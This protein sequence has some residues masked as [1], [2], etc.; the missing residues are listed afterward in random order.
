MRTGQPEPGQEDTSRVADPD[1]VLPKDWRTSPDRV[2]TVLGDAEGLHVLAADSTTA[3]Q[4]G[5]VATL[6]EDGFDSDAWIGNICVTGSGRRAVVA[7]APR[8]FTN[9]P[10][11][12]DRG[13]FTAVVDLEKRTVTK[14]AQQSSL[15]YF[16]PGCGTGET[17]VLTQAADEEVGKTRFLSVDTGTGTVTGDFTVAG[18]ATSAVP[19]QEGVVT[20][21][22]DR[23]TRVGRDGHAELI[24]KTSGPAFHIHPDAEGGVGFL[25]R[26]GD[27]VSVK[28][29]VAGRTTELA[30]GGLGKL[31]LTAGTQGRLFLTG[32][33]QTLATLPAVVKPLKA[34]VG[35][36]TSSHGRLVLDTAVSS[37][38]RTHVAQPLAPVDPAEGAPFRIDAHVPGTGKQ[39]AFTVPQSPAATVGVRSPAL[40]NGP[41]TSASTSPSAAVRA[42]AT[43]S[44]NTTYDPERTC[45]VPRN[46]PAQQALQPTPNQ[47][48]W[49]ADMAIRGNLTSNY[50]AQG[51]WRAEDGLGTAVAPSAMFPQSALIG[52][53]AGSRIPAQ[54]LLGV[55]AQESNLWQASYHALPGQTGN[56]VVGNFY[57]TNIYPG[58]TGYDPEKV[59]TVNWA[60]ADCG[61]GIGQQTDGMSVPGRVQE[62]GKPPAMSADKQRAVALDYAANIAVA[63]Q[64]LSDKWSELH[65]PG[66][67]IK[68]NNDDPKYIENWFAAV[69]NYNLGF[70]KPDAQGK[71]GLGWL[72]NPANP[73]YPADRNAFLDNNHYADAAT[74]QKWPY[75][76]KVMGWAAFPI[77]TGRSY[78]DAGQQ[79]SGNTHGYQAAWWADVAS[80]TGAIKPPLDTFCNAT[81][82]CS[83]GSPPQCGT[84]Y[85]Y[86]QYWYHSDVR[87]KDCPASC[88]N[89]TLTYKTL[90]AELGRGSSGQPNC[91]LSGIP[92]GA[93]VI[94]DVAP[95]VPTMRAGCGKP[96]TSAGSLTWDFAPSSGSTTTYE[97][98]ED[99]H[100][101]GGGLGSHFWFAHTRGGD[102]RITQMR[103]TGTWSLNRDLNQWARVLVHLP[104]TGAETHQA[105]YTIGLGDGTT[106]TRYL[107]QNF[108]SNRWVSLGT[109][110]FKGTPRV[111]LGNETADGTADQDV[112][113]DA[114]AFQPL[115]AKPQHMV[116]VLGDSYTSGEGAGS[117]SPESDANHGK[118][119]WSACRR[120]DNAWA[121]KL[122]L[123]GQSATL[124][125]QA[126]SWSPSAELGF[127]ACS[128]AM[129]RNVWSTGYTPQ[130]QAFE[131][132]Q[133]REINQV[134]SGVLSEDTTLVML[135]LGGNDRGG[136]A[137]AMTDCA[138]MGKNCNEDS[139]FMPKY[140]GIIDDDM[141]PNVTTTL[142]DI[143]SKAPHAKIVLMGYPE[144]LST[145]VKCAGSL[146]FEMPEARAL[147]ELVNYAN[148]KQ[149]DLVSQKVAAGWNIAY[150]NPVAAFGGHSGCDEPEWINKIVV[151]PNGDGDFHQGDPVTKAGGQCTHDWL[152]EACLS[153]E[154]FHPKS[155]GTTGYASVM[156]KR[157][158]EIGYTG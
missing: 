137:G 117:Y 97:G 96:W 70:N 107:N 103:V 130:S 144:L 16:S 30:K 86:K 63:A 38:L 73:K 32:T 11:L 114:V 142:Q 102:S 85:C 50:V 91:S 148:G 61:Y 51:G 87:W 19:V 40:A 127:V 113:W 121:R 39:L 151:G 145:S 100:Q 76:E 26:R 57:G 59:W 56:P 3:Y 135:T 138:G 134:D 65:I 98:K 82:G 33:P 146:Y 109:Y 2:V 120:S 41:K 133:F 24:A 95:G 25:D 20:A 116:A 45:A 149:N 92:A 78:S 49:A 141:I 62:P 21:I 158:Q 153:R 37:S 64:T 83:A 31:S 93:L 88:G 5:E 74:P 13:A 89:E 29:A 27:E 67:T 111:S 104:D 123:P 4:W 58:T 99:L 72:N 112:A 122:T 53:P 44:S 69:W 7:Y 60:K 9:K 71:W 81:N 10:M 156:A 6:R 14:L 75:P 129:T 79:N 42:Q 43:D 115:A 17:A 48:E 108:R 143:R 94:D 118:P 125:A 1:S 47:V 106:R 90:R 139:G 152:P 8:T 110:Q 105:R 140:K 154:S 66:Q 34:E 22:G 124:G 80:R 54:V 119:N 68:V 128:G 36:T 35:A 46:D 12:F 101:V 132:G 84:E 157:L 55:L 23:L 147:A 18:Q 126:D 155:A 28:R 52:G 77:D 15:A 131:E 136:F 150:A